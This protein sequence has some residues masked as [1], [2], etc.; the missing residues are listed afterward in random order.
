MSLTLLRHAP[1]HQK[2][3]QKYL[4]WSDVD[5]DLGLFDR[6]KT[7]D[8][9]KQ[10]FDYVFSSDLKRCTQTVAEIGFSFHVDRRLREVAFKEKIELKSFLEI[11][12][13][14]CFKEE[15]LKSESAWFDYVAKES[16]DEYADRIKSFISVLNLEKNILICSHKGTINMILQLF[17]ESQIDLEYLQNYTLK[18]YDVLH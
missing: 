2:Y 18:C 13:L 4:G 15:Y 3:H 8:L 17:G 9:R 1:P 12:K 11:E 14:P 6:S 5:I 7:E 16:F 10:T